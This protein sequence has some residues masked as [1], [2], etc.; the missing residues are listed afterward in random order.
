MNNNNCQAASQTVKS[1]TVNPLPVPIISGPASAASN[2]TGN[3]YMTESGMS[4]YIWSVSPGGTITTGSGTNS[5]IVTWNVA[6]PQ[7]VSVTYSNTNNCSSIIPTIYNVTVGSLLNG[8][9]NSLTNVACF[10]ANNGSV[11][12]AGSGGVSPYEYKLGTGSY[13]SSGTFSSLA[14]GSYTITVRDASLNTFDVQATITEPEAL[15]TLNSW[16]NNLCFGGATGSATV[17]AF[18]GNKSLQLFM[19]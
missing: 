18:G 8:N 14:A 13:Q 17:T 4:G 1:I 9:I 11:T 3:V 5:I 15:Y 16:V 6:G 19:E 12:V 10:G 2:S 7:N